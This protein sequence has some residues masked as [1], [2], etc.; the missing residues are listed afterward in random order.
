MQVSLPRAPRIDLE[1]RELHP[2]NLCLWHD[3]RLARARVLE[4]DGLLQAAVGLDQRL[5]DAP[6]V[7]RICVS[8][9]LAPQAGNT[10]GPDHLMGS[11]DGA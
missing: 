8:S 6:V 2:G 11:G 10:Y 3:V 1:D 7:A 9:V 4:R 5:L